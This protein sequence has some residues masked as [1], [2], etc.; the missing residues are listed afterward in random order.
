MQGNDMVRDK[1]LEGSRSDGTGNG[2]G[3]TRMEGRLARQPLFP[4]RQE[5]LRFCVEQ[6]RTLK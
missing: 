5:R 1:G 3:K 6:R 4:S 2:L